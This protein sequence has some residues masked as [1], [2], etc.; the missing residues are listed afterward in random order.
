MEFKKLQLSDIE[1]INGY[2]KICDYRT[3]DFT[4]GGSFIWRDYFNTYYYEND[5]TVIFRMGGDGQYFYSYPIGKN[6]DAMLALLDEECKTPSFYLCDERDVKKISERYPDRKVCESRDEFDYLYD[7]DSLATFKGKKFSGQRNHVNKFKK[8]YPTASFEE[9]SEKNI[10]AC[11]DFFLSFLASHEKYEATD[12]EAN[13]IL[14][15]FDNYPLYEKYGFFGGV[16]SFE[17]QVVGFSVAENVG[18][19][20]YVHIEKADISYDGA[21]QML[22]CSFASHFQR[23]GVLY[24]NREDDAGDEGLRRSKLSYHPIEL[25]P[26]YKV[27]SD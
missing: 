20:M 5:D 25:L 14:E 10:P 19:I 4:L 22:V 2:F 27:V 9:L 16:L 6:P 18:D 17:G 3:C 11:R 26:K 23:D 24:I 12:E 15:I 21:Y 8:L 1:K 7:Y 13:K